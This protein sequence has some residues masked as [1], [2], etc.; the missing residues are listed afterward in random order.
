MIRRPPRSTLF[1]YTTLFRSIFFGKVTEWQGFEQNKKQ[2]LRY[3]FSVTLTYWS[4]SISKKRDAYTWEK[5][6][7]QKSSMPIPSLLSVT[8]RTLVEKFD[9]CLF[10]FYIPRAAEKSFGT[11]AAEKKLGPE[12]SKWDLRKVIGTGEK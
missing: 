9:F 7:S 8:R 2:K 5:N 3:I 12:K 11:G 1:P 6:I 4:N 10:L